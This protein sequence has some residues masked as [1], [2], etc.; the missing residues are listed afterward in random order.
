MDSSSVGGVSSL[1]N[2]LWKELVQK[3]LRES[4]NASLS[5]RKRQKPS[6]QSLLQILNL[7]IDFFYLDSGITCKTLRYILLEIVE[8][9]RQLCL[10]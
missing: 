8:V 6:S 7:K 9:P 4:E 3:S 10:V 5:L 1:I 2:Q